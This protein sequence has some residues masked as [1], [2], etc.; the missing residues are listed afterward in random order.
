MPFLL[1]YFFRA[2]LEHLGK[3]PPLEDCLTWLTGSSTQAGTVPP[4]SSSITLW[5]TARPRHDTGN[6]T[7]DVKITL[8]AWAFES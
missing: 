2:D 5:S 3:G 7:R 8:G 6:Q 1:A 4:Y